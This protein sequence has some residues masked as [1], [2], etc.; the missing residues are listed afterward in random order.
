VAR[1]ALILAIVALVFSWAAY[2]RAGGQLKEIW[3]DVTRGAADFRV[4]SPTVGSP[5]DSGA[6]N[7]LKQGGAKALSTLDSAV[8]KIRHVAGGEKKGGR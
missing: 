8:E 4:G 1:L 3:S 5:M 2:R 7:K 6:A